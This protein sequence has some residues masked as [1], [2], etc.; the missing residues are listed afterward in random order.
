M[1][2]LVNQRRFL[3]TKSVEEIQNWAISVSQ[4]MS[5]AD[6]VPY[7]ISGDY[8]DRMKAEILQLCIRIRRA[9]EY[10]KKHQDIL[11]KVQ[12]SNMEFY[13]DMLALRM[14]REGWDW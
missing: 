10:L 13:F 7:M 11:L 6:T 5:L 4:W 9:K 3:L 2:I 14:E 1:F 12:L 8:K